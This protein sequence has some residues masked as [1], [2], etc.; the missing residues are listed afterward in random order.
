MYL[1]ANIY[2][3]IYRILYINKDI[4]FYMCVDVGGKGL[5]YIGGYIDTI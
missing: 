4:I 5:R 1:Y 3:A 2:T